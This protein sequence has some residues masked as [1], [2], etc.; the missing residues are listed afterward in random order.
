MRYLVFLQIH[1][2]SSSQSATKNKKKHKS[3]GHERRGVSNRRQKREEKRHMWSC[4]DNIG[5]STRE[6]ADNIEEIN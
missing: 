4:R 5:T 6:T 3:V 1:M 2:R